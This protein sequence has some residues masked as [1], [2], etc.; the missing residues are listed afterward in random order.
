MRG[1][2]SKT[3][4]GSKVELLGGDREEVLTQEEQGEGT[5]SRKRRVILFL[6]TRWWSM[7]INNNNHNIHQ[8]DTG[9]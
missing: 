6:L 8:T 3:Q 7:K 1:Q 4:L 2:Q 9:F 5:Y